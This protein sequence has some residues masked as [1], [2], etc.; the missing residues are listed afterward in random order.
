M[1][2]DIHP[3]DLLD[4]LS[5][6][7]ISPPE[8]ERLRAHLARCASCRF[9]LS[10]RGDFLAE[11]PVLA[12]R[13]QLGL[14]AALQHSKRGVA[15]PEV[16]VASAWRRRRLA[17]AL[18]AA[19]LVISVAGAAA[20]S[21]AGAR[22]LPWAFRAGTN[23]VLEHAP[24]AG[25]AA[26]AP[27]HA[28]AAATSMEVPA[29]VSDA[30]PVESAASALASSEP[31]P[32]IQPRT[33]SAA[34]VKATS[35]ATPALPSASSAAPQAASTVDFTAAIGSSAP[36]MASAVPDAPPVVEDAAAVFSEANRARRDGNAERAELLYRGLQ[37]RFPG[38][39][40]S[41]LSREVLAQMLLERGNVTGA[42][43]GFDR[44]LAG[45]SNGLAAEALVGRA[46]ALEQL[47]QRDQAAAAWRDVQRRYPGT[48]HAQLAKARLAILDPE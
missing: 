32:A 43:A 47:S 30:P 16:R 27:K 29:A 14:S 18:V 12:E 36:S 21:G 15:K 11:V 38:S 35:L 2:V 39:A 26:S 45:G 40:E 7:E 19:A 42:L 23:D 34:L 10:V 1:T 48:V 31:S 4:K 9:E 22:V 17:V 41:E 8:E 13:P 25:R 6:G 46:R 24:N 5:D 3:E 20:V 33:P 44:Y 37:A 28:N